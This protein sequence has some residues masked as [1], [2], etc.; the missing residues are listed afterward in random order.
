MNF[1][2]R[3]L[4]IFFSSFQEDL[5]D[6][7][8]AEFKVILVHLAQWA[9]RFSP[10]VSPDL[11]FREIEKDDPRFYGINLDITG[12]EK[13]FYS[14]MAL[15]RKISDAL[16]RFGL[17]HRLAIAPSLGAA[18]ALSRYGEKEITIVERKFLRGLVAP[19]PISCLRLSKKIEES[20]KDLNISTVEDVL[21]LPRRS[22]LERFGKTIL[23][24]LDK[25]LAFQQEVI[26]PIQILTLSRVEQVFEGAVVDNE[27]IKAAAGELL[28]E[29]LK[30]LRQRHLQPTQIVIQL[31]TVDGP[32]IYKDFSLSIPTYNFKHIVKLLE[33]RLDTVAA[34]YGIEKL[35]LIANRSEKF[36]PKK[37]PFLQLH[38]TNIEEEESLG[39][40]LDSLA[41][42]LD[43]SQLLIPEAR[44]SYLPEES[45]S[46]VP[47][48]DQESSSQVLIPRTERPSVILNKPEP[49][50]AMASLP[51]G[52]PFWMKW[53][54]N[55]YEVSRSVGPER[56]TPEWWKE[57]MIELEP[58]DYFKIQI[59]NGTWLW[60]FRELKSS[61]WFLQGMWT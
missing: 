60:I 38:S 55:T 59:P 45:F 8:V 52:P 51:D 26:Q 28:R 57:R 5:K 58:R 20:L 18:W 43:K 37:S 2:K 13:L 53:K 49:I 10:I 11:T 34:P 35:S 30:K 56:I 31:K 46:L 7:P 19:L 23:D 36:N 50:R 47:F 61:N 14:E 39:E 9:Y 12:C 22:L 3:I 40:L 17:K 29:L 21:A 48:M 6:R 33:R 25:I 24:R 16:K 32:L 44:A 15:V 1:S 41:E 54:E 4:S 42:N 27:T